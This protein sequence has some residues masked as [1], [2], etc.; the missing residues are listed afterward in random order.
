MRCVNA[1]GQERAVAAFDLEQ[2]CERGSR[3]TSGR[4]L[5]TEEQHSAIRMPSRERGILSKKRALWSCLR[6]LAG[7]AATPRVNG[8]AVWL[9]AHPH[10]A[11][12]RQD[13]T[14]V[15]AFGLARGEGFVDS[16]GV[17]ITAKRMGL[18]ARDEANCL[19]GLAWQ[20]WYREHH[21][22]WLL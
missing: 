5:H 22:I 18:R 14:N 15:V 19:A 8:V 2:R 16:E 6:T 11:D 12:Y 20:R 3:A 1:G 10:A 4:T 17:W 13:L 9:H 21:T 7:R